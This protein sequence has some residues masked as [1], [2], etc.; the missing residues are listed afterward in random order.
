MPHAKKENKIERK[1]AKDYINELCFQRSCNN[2]IYLEARKQT[3]FFLWVMKSP[4]GP[5]IK[6]AVQNIHT[7][8]ELKLTGNCL[9]F[10]RPLLSFDSSFNAEPHLQLMKEMLHQAFNTPKNHPKSKPFI[11]HVLSFNYYD[12]RV[13]FRVYQVVNQHEEKFTEVDDIEKLTLIEIGPRFC[14]QP[15]KIF[16]GTL[17]GEALWQNDKYITPGKLRSKK[18]DAF[19]RRRD[20]KGERKE[21]RDNTLKKGVDPDAYL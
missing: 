1:I 21:Y 9:K 10:S 7:L 4:E 15:I 18:Y 14:L 12:D 8:D 16:G 11:D 20:Q 17:G 19:V 6:F 3:D 2:C 13:W 5:S